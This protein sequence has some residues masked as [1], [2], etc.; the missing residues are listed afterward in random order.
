MTSRNPDLPDDTDTKSR[1]TGQRAA[2]LLLMRGVAL[3]LLGV[4]LVTA[5]TLGW[6]PFGDNSL[7]RHGPQLIGILIISQGAYWVAR[8]RS[9]GHDGS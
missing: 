3:T 6:L 1:S 8:S 2:R 4:V 9:H 5:A 7:V